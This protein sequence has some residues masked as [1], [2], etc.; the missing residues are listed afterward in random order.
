MQSEPERRFRLDVPKMSFD[1]YLILI[2]E[3]LRCKFD[4]TLSGFNE[5]DI[6]R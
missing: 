1:W 4:R 5:M 2:T 6:R 3:D